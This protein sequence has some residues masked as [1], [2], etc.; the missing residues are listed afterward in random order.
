MILKRLQFLTSLQWRLV[1]I[2]ILLALVL[3]VSASVSLNYF[4]ELFFYDTFKAGIENGFEYWGIDDED[5]PTKEEIVS[6]LTANNKANAMSLFFINNF[7]TF[8]IID[9]NTNEIIYTDV[10]SPYRETLREDIIQS[11]N[12][13]AALA[14]GKGDK[15]KLIRI[16][17]SPFL[18][19]Q[20]ELAI[21]IIFYTSGMTGKSGPEQ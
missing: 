10:K 16:G 12:Y 5:Q 14:G 7:R 11:R 8:T 9:K 13:L 18:T 2:F 15:G 6:F 19:M 3:A 4:V 17:T 20:D 21:R 1:T